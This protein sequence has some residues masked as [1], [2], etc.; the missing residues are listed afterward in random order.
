MLSPGL[1]L[2]TGLTCLFQPVAQTTLTVEPLPQQETGGS[3]LAVRVLET[4]PVS[5][6]EVRRRHALAGLQQPTGGAG[7]VAGCAGGDTV[8]VTGPVIPD[9]RVA[10]G[11]TERVAQGAG[12][13]TGERG[14]LTEVP[15]GGEGGVGED[16][17]RPTQPPVLATLPLAGQARGET[18]AGA[19]PVL[20]RVRRDTDRPLVTRHQ[21]SRTLSSTGLRHTLTHHGVAH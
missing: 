17:L 18:G 9:V 7:G 14:L 19:V 15:A 5:W 4:L 11:V 10:G 20:R 12:A 3:L 8:S 16:T 2:E 21:A 13:V 6:A 1:G